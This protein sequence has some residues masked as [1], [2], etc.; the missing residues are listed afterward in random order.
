MQKK[1]LILLFTFLL[2]FSRGYSLDLYD[3][4]ERDRIK[5]IDEKISSIAGILSV[6]VV[7]MPSLYATGNFALLTITGVQACQNVTSLVN[8]LRERYTITKDAKERKEILD[9]IEKLNS[10]N[11]MDGYRE[12]HSDEH[13]SIGDSDRIGGLGG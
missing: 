2:F 4:N 11:S 13:S 12:N 7:T 3:E 1:T 9:T 10:E 5:E 8:L 6:E